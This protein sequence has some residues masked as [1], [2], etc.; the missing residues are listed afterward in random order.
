[1]AFATLGTDL[2]L[3]PVPISKRR[4]GFAAILATVGA[5]ASVHVHMIFS[6]V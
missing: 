1:M 3:V 4:E 6:I 5:L 2:V